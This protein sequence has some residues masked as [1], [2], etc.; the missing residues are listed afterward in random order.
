MLTR[1]RVASVLHESGVLVLWWHVDTVNAPK[2]D[3]TYGYDVDEDKKQGCH[4]AN[5][6][7][8]DDDCEGKS[9]GSDAPVLLPCA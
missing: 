5:P 8:R 4:T 1:I 3:K 9:R 6:D 7:R 2:V